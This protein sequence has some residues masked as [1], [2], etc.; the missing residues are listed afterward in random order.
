[1]NN[2]GFGFDAFQLFK[3][4]VCHDGPNA[5]DFTLV[6]WMRMKTERERHQ[7]HNSTSS[8]ISGYNKAPSSEWT[9]GKDKEKE[10]DT[11]TTR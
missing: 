10:D 4:F 3:V 6:W 5:R 11:R 9:S 1:M 7:T 2:S 8:Q